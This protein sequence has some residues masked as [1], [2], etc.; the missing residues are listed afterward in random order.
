[1]SCKLNLFVVFPL[2]KPCKVILVMETRQTFSIRLRF[3]KDLK[4]S[5]LSRAVILDK[6]LIVLLCCAPHRCHLTFFKKN[7]WRIFVGFV[8]LL[9]SVLN[10]HQNARIARDAV[11]NCR[12][13]NAWNLTSLPLTVLAYWLASS[14]VSPW[15]FSKNVKKLSKN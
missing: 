13:A 7:F 3:W 1:M 12:K 15:K 10:G 11:V 4:T 8:W 14:N 9:A 6:L 5:I 2:K